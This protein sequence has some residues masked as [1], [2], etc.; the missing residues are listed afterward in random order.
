M[1]IEYAFSGASCEIALIGELDHHAAKTAISEINARLDQTMP[2]HLTLNMR[3]VSFMD[4]S[5]IALILSLYKHLQAS[6]G[7][8]SLVSLPPSVKRILQAAG[9]ERLM[10]L[11]A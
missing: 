10:D 2:F 11:S 8:F 9:M 6:G 4:S 7:T 3:Q 5:G 1:R